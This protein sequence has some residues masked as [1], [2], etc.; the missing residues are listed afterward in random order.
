FFQNCKKEV[1]EWPPQ[2]PD[3]NLIENLWSLL[4]A[5]IPLEKRSNKEEFLNEL[6]L[7]FQRIDKHY[8]EK[9][10]ENMLRRI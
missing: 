6:Q 5:E 3:L 10:V 7:K 8:L 1:L 2:S 4:D 9:L